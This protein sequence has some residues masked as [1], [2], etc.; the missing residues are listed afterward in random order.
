LIHE[1]TCNLKYLFFKYL[2]MPVAPGNWR[3]SGNFV[4]ADGRVE[5]YSR[6]NDREALIIHGLFL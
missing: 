6:E 3:E 5:K 2:Q 4:F 1:A